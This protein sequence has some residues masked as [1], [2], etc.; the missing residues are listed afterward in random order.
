MKFIINKYELIQ[1]YYQENS[2]LKFRDWKEKMVAA[3]VIEPIKGGR[4]LI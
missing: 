1:M 3:G 2:R 4:Y